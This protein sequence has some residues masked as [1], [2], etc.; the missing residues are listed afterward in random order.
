MVELDS[1]QGSMSATP[2]REAYYRGDIQADAFPAGTINFLQSF[3]NTSIYQ[4]LQDKFLTQDKSNL[5]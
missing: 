4:Q 3:Q 2:V 1:M 5:P